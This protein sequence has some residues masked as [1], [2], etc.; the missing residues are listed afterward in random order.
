VPDQFKK[1]ILTPMEKWEKQLERIQQL[2]QQGFLTAEEASRARLKADDDLANATKK[3][4]K[5]IGCP[6]HQRLGLSFAE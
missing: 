5:V 6:V 2:Q 4:E 1:D 3:H